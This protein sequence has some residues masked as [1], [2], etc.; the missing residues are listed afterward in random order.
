MV[1]LQDCY[2]DICNG[3][4]CAASLLSVFERSY[5]SNSWVY[6]SHK[7]LSDDLLGFYNTKLIGP[8]LS[9][10]LALGFLKM[11]HSP[12]KQWVKFWEFQPLAVNMA[13]GRAKARAAETSRAAL[14]EC[15]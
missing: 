9:H 2:L 6:K 15:G 3:D 7:D 4:R 13:L 11:R 1:A 14:G 5:K 12:D 10:L 8:A